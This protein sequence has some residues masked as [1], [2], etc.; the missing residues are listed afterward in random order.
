MIDCNIGVIVREQAYGNLQSYSSTLVESKLL[1]KMATLLQSSVYS[2]TGY[3]V[4]PSLRF[5]IFN[6]L[7][8]YLGYF[9]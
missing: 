8:K 5:L 7:I 2:K 1:L 6:L 9:S 3:E 4:V